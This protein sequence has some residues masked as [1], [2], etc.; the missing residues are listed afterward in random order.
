MRKIEKSSDFQLRFLGKILLIAS[1]GFEYGTKDITSFH[2]I[3]ENSL[4]KH[5][6]FTVNGN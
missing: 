6:I 2:S 3:V 5:A 4:S 1:S